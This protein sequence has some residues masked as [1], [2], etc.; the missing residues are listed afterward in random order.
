MAASHYRLGSLVAVVDANGF[1]GSGPTSA[2]MNIEPLAE[3]FTAFG[4]RASEVDG[5][6]PDALMRAFADL[7]DP[8]SEQPVCIIARTRKGHGAALLEGAPQAWH[9]GLLPPQAMAEVVEEITARMD[10]R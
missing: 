4:W 1:S 8:D 6:D 9:L 10:G 3:R 5:H 7:P 2:A